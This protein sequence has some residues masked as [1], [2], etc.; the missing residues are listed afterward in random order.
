[1]HWR[2]ISLQIY[3]GGFTRIGSRDSLCLVEVEG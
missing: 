1:M 3:F 2:L